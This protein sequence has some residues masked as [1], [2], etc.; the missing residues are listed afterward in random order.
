MRGTEKERGR[1]R[2][3]EKER[4]TARGREGGGE[5]QTRREGG[6]EGQREGQGKS[7]LFTHHDS[8]MQVI[9]TASHWKCNA[10]DKEIQLSPII[11]RRF[12]Y[13]Q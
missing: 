10:E 5:G 13:L 11:S 9:I 1:G 12:N 8:C 4:G 3:T 2:G 7:V 6:G